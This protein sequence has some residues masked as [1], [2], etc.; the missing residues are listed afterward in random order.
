MQCTRW[1]SEKYSGQFDGWDLPHYG[2]VA[3]AC[4]FERALPMRRR[5]SD[6]SPAGDARCVWPAP[7][8]T[9]WLRRSGQRSDETQLRSCSPERRRLPAP[10]NGPR[11]AP[12]GDCTYDVCP[13]PARATAHSRCLRRSGG[14]PAWA[15]RHAVQRLCSAACAPCGH[16]SPWRLRARAAPHLPGALGLHTREPA[17]VCLAAVSC[18]GEQLRGSSCAAR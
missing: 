2:Y 14:P 17:P 5:P 7:A 10:P 3:C 4:I 13:P 11:S 15:V 18:L 12:S 6:G 1:H 8:P 9:G 16:A